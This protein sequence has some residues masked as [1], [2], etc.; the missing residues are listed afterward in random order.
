MDFYRN[1][2]Y[3]IKDFNFVNE[4]DLNIASKDIDLY[5]KTG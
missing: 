3:K 1:F 2:F 4:D 5:M